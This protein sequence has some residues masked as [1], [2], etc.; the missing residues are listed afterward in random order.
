MSL[1]EANKVS[2]KEQI[3]YW[4]SL[5]DKALYIKDKSRSY[6]VFQ[7]SDLSL[8]TAMPLKNKHVPLLFV[9]RTNN[10]LH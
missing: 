5:S 4:L 1:F 9:Q 3:Q 7:I 10:A 2:A 8:E 6:F